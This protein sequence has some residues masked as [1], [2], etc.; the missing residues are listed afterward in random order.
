MISIIIPVWNQH[1]MTAECIDAV[2]RHTNVPYEIILVDNGS[3]PPYRGAAVRNIDNLGFPVAVNQG[4]RASKGD[5][6]CLLNNDVIVTPGWAGRMVKALAKYDIVGPMANYA[7]GI[8]L[9]T[10][11][12]Y[13]GIEELDRMAVRFSENHPGQT[14]DV[15]WVTGFCYMF[16]RSLYDEIGEFDESLW[17]CS[18][19]EIDFCKRA[20]QAGKRVAICKDVYV[21]HEGSR[22]FDAMGVDYNKIVE[23]NDKH[24]E[25]KWGKGIWEDQA[26][27]NNGGVR[28]NLGSGPFP[29]RGFVNID[30]DEERKPDVVADVTKLPYEPGT[31]DEIYAGHLLEH[32]D[33]YGGEKALW[34][35]RDMLKPG[36]KIAVCVPDY[37][38]LV[39]DYLRSPSAFKLREMN[40]LYI[41]SYMQKSPHK[42]A[43]S[44]VL[45]RDSMERAGFVDLQRMPVNH[46]YFQSPV[47]WQVG[48]EGRKPK[49]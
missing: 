33:Y 12:S 29:L 41:Y 32:F 9:I 42:Y 30:Q 2:K 4:I 14:V 19:E 45:L 28:L 39:R 22:T 35:W 7:A 47:E 20:R 23:R 46:P 11:D 8:Q 16:R 3:S 31:V 40:D 27:I 13:S 34:H 6:I 38:F 43:Y 44:E 48:I 15:N 49:A 26:I 10:T 17:P 25:D 21:H 24:L 36:G 37:D 1:D 5:I 18:G